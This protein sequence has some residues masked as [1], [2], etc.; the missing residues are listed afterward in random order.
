MLSPISSASSGAPRDF[1]RWSSGVS[2]RQ[3]SLPYYFDSNPY[4]FET[5]FLLIE[6]SF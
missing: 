5:V 2:D 1:L 6:I 3:A 4:L